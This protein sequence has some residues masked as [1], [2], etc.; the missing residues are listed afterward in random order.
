MVQFLSGADDSQSDS[1]D[2]AV[3]YQDVDDAPL[4]KKSLF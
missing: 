1:S 3:P 4:G 2:M